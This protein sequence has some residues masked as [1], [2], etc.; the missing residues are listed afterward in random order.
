MIL[1]SE[2]S[3]LNC[4]CF[5]ELPLKL[6]YG[7]INAFHRN[8]ICNHSAIHSSQVYFVSKWGSTTIELLAIL[9]LFSS[10]EKLLISPSNIIQMPLGSAVLLY[11]SHIYSDICHKQKYELSPRH[12]HFPS[13]PRRCHP[14][15]HRAIG[16][17][18]R[19]QLVYHSQTLEWKGLE[20]MYDNDNTNFPSCRTVSSSI[21]MDNFTH[22][23]KQISLACI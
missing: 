17:Q 13:S 8:K 1:C 2:R 6:R 16:Y 10:T 18:S 3:G 19:F 15:H 4:N 12:V 11:P 14:L 22:H 23:W 9:R 21:S 20:Y 7:L 5:A